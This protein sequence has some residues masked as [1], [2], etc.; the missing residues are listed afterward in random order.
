MY[1]FSPNAP[2][3]L[4]KPIPEKKFGATMESIL[5]ALPTK[6]QALQQITAVW[7]LSQN[8]GLVRA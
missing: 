2:A 8:I 5:D 6:H 1:A 3:L 7:S 4:R